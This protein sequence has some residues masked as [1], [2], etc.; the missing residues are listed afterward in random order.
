[1]KA[2]IFN[3]QR[4]S[5]HD[6]P[7]IR[8][9]VFFKGCPLRCAWCSNPEG[10]SL[11]K[12]RIYIEEK[13]LYCHKCIDVCPNNAI[14]IIKNKLIW[15]KKLCDFCGK[16][17]DSCYANTIKIYGEFV[18]SDY[19]FN[20]IKKDLIFYIKSNGGVTFG[21]GEPLL[22]PDFIKEVSEKCK[23]ENI[24]TAIETCGFTAWRNF[25][26]ILPVTD[27]ILY[28]LKHMD[29]EIHK[30]ICRKSNKIILENLKKLAATDLKKII[31]R[32]PVIPGIN[33]SIK[34]IQNTAYFVS[35]LNVK[36]INLLPYFKYHLKKYD[37]LNREYE[38]LNL[39]PPAEE[40]MFRL[41]SVFEK[42][43]LNVQIGG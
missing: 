41:K 11:K 10:Q 34:N 33:D 27:M 40:E 1:M 16:C 35:K 5:I 7:G 25:Q 22:W 31:I 42:Y 15:K 13:C 39:N 21:G 20:E 36:E 19:V 28:D 23:T 43:D 6:G 32:I 38:L 29:P 4:F 8:T 30:K 9:L 26:K 2:L 24:H 12:D 17:E 18:D 14:K 37:R 3:I